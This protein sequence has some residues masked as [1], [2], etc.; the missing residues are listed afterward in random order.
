MHFWNGFIH[1][2]LLRTPQEEHGYRFYGER[3]YGRL[4]RSE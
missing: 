4:I 2:M 1:A 3:V